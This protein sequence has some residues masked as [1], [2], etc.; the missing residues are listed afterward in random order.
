MPEF[1]GGSGESS[2]LRFFM[3]GHEPPPNHLDCTG[4][5][6]DPNRSVLH[7]WWRRL[8]EV[9]AG[10]N[11]AMRSTAKWVAVRHERSVPSELSLSHEEPPGSRRP[12]GESPAR[13]VVGTPR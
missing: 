6:Q 9:L 5:G 4:T 12:A 13:G 8:L 10:L 2:A 3:Y 1:A 7:T 11:G